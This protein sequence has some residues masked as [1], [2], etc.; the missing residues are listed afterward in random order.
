MVFVKRARD[1]IRL[2]NMVCGRSYEWKGRSQKI[3]VV[4]RRE[5]YEC[6]V[7]VCRWYTMRGAN[8][9]DA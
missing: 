8:A 4:I 5:R 1:E 2:G 3:Y 6:G 9:W 7:G